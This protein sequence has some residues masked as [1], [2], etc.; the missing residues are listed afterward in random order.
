MQGTKLYIGNLNYTVTDQQ[1]QDLFSS[2]G[3][4]KHIN[5]ITG[6]GFGFVEFSSTE[7]AQKAKDELDGADFEGRKLRIDEARPQRA[8]PRRDTRR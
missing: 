6:R 2:Y 1:L 5:V 8:R 3:E 7:E 4:V